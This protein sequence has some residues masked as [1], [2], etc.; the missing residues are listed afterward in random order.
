MAG[1]D[2]GVLVNAAYTLAD[3]GENISTMMVL[4][5]RALELNPNFAR[6]W[7]ISGTLRVWA[8]QT[9]IAI[10]HSK[11][12]LRLSPRV[13]VGPSVMTIG[14]AH[15]LARRFDEAVPQLL[16]AMQEDPSHPGAYRWLASCYA[17]MRR[18]D[19]ARQVVEQLRTFTQEV[20]PNVSFLRNPEHRELFLSG[21]RLAIGAEP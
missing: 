16:L 12:A 18:L 8:G 13:R 19:D 5:D 3:F 2:P 10:E 9:E 4:V 6:G 7:Y 17:H 20:I 15:F 1:D 11:I 14:A 21:L